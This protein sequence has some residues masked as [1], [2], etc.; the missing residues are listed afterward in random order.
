MFEQA[1]EKLLKEQRE[2][3]TGRRLEMLH[4]DL[5]GTKKLLEAVV[6]PVLRSFEGII[7]EHEIP[8]PTGVTVYVD[9]FYAPISAALECEGFVVHAE[10]ITRSR[11][12]FEKTR[13]RMMGLRGIVYMPFS[14]DQLDKQPEL[15]RQSFYELLGRYTS[16]GGSAA[17]EKLTPF[18]REVI[19]YGLHLNRP[20]R[21]ED[22]KYCL[23]CE[24]RRAHTV[25]KDL[26]EKNLMKPV[27]D[28]AI[29]IHQYL[30][31]PEARDVLFRK[32][33]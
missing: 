1:Y 25:V 7:L 31:L 23:Q 10:K 21:L 17:M 18:E 15:C 32:R 9:A 29:R 13:V 6:W 5:T 4:L 20:L 3:A 16:A 22:V 30:L 12:D 33:Y 26:V 27:K 8:N 24:Y 2:S 19:R 11:F 28:S 14:K